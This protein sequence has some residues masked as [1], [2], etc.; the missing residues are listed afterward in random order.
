MFSGARPGWFGVHVHP[1]SEIVLSGK[2]E[3]PSTEA[4]LP[5]DIRR[6]PR[7]SV[8]LALPALTDKHLRNRGSGSRVVVR[9]ESAIPVR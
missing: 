9:S 5:A 2:R 7:D 4:L 3:R 6:S 8:G 1:E